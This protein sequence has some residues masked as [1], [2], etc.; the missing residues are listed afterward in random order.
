M[1]AHLEG[2]AEEFANSSFVEELDK[3]GFIKQAAN[4]PRALN[5]QS[6][7]LSAEAILISIIRTAVTSAS[8][9][10]IRVSIRESARLSQSICFA[11]KPSRYFAAKQ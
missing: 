10:W 2:I 7:H 1:K 11:A 9:P 5:C 3:S 4:P 8:D 6:G